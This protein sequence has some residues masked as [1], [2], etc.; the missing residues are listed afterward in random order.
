MISAPRFVNFKSSDT[1]TSSLVWWKFG[2]QACTCGKLFRAIFHGDRC[3][4]SPL[5]NFG[6]FD[7]STS[8]TLRWSEGNSIRQWICG[9][10][11]TM[12]L[13]VA[14]HV[15]YIACEGRRTPN[16]IVFSR[17]TVWWCHLVEQRQ[18][19]K[20]VHNYLSLNLSISNISLCLSSNSWMATLHPRTWPFYKHDRQINIKLLC[21]PTW[22]H[23]Q[24]HGDR[25]VY[26]TS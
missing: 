7:A 15:H 24:F 26:L 10:L 3:M 14:V 19:Y 12:K 25:G 18:S 13:P 20:Q 17:S 1:Y 9:M 6:I 23:M 5:T 11:I 8:T 2:M 4:M 16:V 22:R 21:L